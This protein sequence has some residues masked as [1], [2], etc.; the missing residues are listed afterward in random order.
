MQTQF[1]RVRVQ[2][3]LLNKEDKTADS[4]SEKKA[5]AWGSSSAT[6]IRTSSSSVPSSVSTKVIVDSDKMLKELTTALGDLHR[7]E[8]LVLT[9][10]L[11]KEL[12][13]MRAEDKKAEKATRD[14]TLQQQTK[15]KTEVVV[16]EKPQL[17]LNGEITAAVQQ[18]TELKACDSMLTI[19]M[20]KDA[21]VSTTP[22]TSTAPETS[23]AVGP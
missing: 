8:R 9:E 15:M 5:T 13:K 16:E 20:V 21:S 4:H 18:G 17:L 11:I 3:T 12:K 10:M 22:T 2:L 19:Q 1:E 6:D 7:E 23:T 14:A